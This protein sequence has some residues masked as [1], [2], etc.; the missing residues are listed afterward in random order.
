[1]TTPNPVG[2]ADALVCEAGPAGGLVGWLAQAALATAVPSTTVISSATRPRPI[3]GTRY[4]AFHR[5]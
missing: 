5:I 4:P 2:F 3:T 1:M